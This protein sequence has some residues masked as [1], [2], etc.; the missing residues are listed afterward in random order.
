MTE[1]EQFCGM[2]VDFPTNGVLKLLGGDIIVA[3]NDVDYK[4]TG[5]AETANDVQMNDVGYLYTGSD[6]SDHMG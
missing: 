3:G 4:Y 1:G 2:A 5:S 6:G